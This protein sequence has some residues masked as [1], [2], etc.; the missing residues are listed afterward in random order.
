MRRSAALGAVALVCALLAPA[1]VPAAAELPTTGALP[2]GGTYVLYRDPTLATAAIDLWFRA[3]GA[4][5]DGA[6]PGIARLAATAVAAAPLASG[7]TLVALVRSLGGHLAIQAFPDM[8]GVSVVVP[9]DAARRVVAAM[10]AAY[11]D[12]ALDADAL[13][14]AQSDVTVLAAQRRYL[15]DSLAHD[16]LFAQIFSAGPAHEPPLPDTAGALAR[17]PLADVEAFARRAFRSANATLSLAGDVAPTALDAVTAGTPGA[18]DAPLDSTL[19]ADPHANA[20]LAANVPGAGLAWVGPPIRDERAATALDFVADYLFRDGSGVVAKALDASD[21]PAYVSGQFITLHDPGVF[22]VTLSGDD[23]SVART[24]VLEAIRA[25]QHPLDAATF[26]RA[27]EAFLFHLASDTQ[28]ASEQ[29]DNLGWYATEGNAAYAPSAMQSTYWQ[30]ARG[31]DPAF[32]ASVVQRYLAHPV[33]VQL[34]TA[35]AK[36]STT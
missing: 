17:L 4:G 30:T 2:H 26:A 29:A 10:S 7:T 13:K 12:P 15:A 35:T 34:T 24:R 5:Y 1:R 27:R 20:T 25:L 28:Y 8:I 22:L 3:P 9:S 33:A 14:I 18:P 36:E 32:V 31:L 19:A 23:V 21:D 11:F 16:A 6:N